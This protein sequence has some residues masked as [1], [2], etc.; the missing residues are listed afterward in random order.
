MRCLVF[1]GNG[2]LGG[3]LC[4]ALLSQGYTVRVFDRPVDNISSIH[5]DVEWFEGDFIN[6]CDVNAAI[7]DCDVIFHLISTTLPKSSNDNPVYDVESNV[8]GTLNMLS[9]ALKHGVKK[10]IFTSSGGT[11]Y[12]VPEEIPISE[13][14]PT[15]PICSY[16][17][18]KLAIEKYLYLFNALHGLEYSVLRISNPYGK[19]QRL[20]AVQGVV[21]VV[22][23]RVLQNK[24]V[25]IWGTGEVVR[26]YIH[27]SDVSQALVQAMLYDGD[28]HIFNIGSGE[29]TSL[30][31]LLDT[32][33]DVMQCD[34]NRNYQPER[35]V[36]IQVN[37]LD[38]ALAKKELGWDAKVSLREGI[39]MTIRDLS[40][41]LKM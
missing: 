33:E 12:G 29:G 6:E 25:D 4:E 2:F 26:D 35:S 14:H 10:V 41:S 17:I 40:S 15:N 8:V 3:E 37:V 38:N 9:A 5:P 16:G 23:G 36:D 13:K 39:S 31:T 18:S 30:N 32:I 7:L 27:V 22:I 28:Q 24:P 19:G 11:I 21:G 20:D 34:I 1:G